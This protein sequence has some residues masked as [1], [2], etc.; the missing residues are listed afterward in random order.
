MMV[1]KTP[2]ILDRMKRP[3]TMPQMVSNYMLS[4]YLYCLALSACL[5]ELMFLSV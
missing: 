4:V 5:S 3:L 1:L 2:E